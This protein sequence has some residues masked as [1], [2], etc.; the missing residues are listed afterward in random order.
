MQAGLG[1]SRGGA[2]NLSL[3][4]T[5]L[6]PALA[7]SGP[8]SA[9]GALFG[10]ALLALAVYWLRGLYVQATRGRLMGLWWGVGGWLCLFLAPIL[11]VPALFGLGAAALL[12]GEYWRGASRTVQAKN[13]PPASARAWPLVMTVL[14]LF[15]SGSAA[16]AL[17]TAPAAESDSGDLA[18]LALGL[19]CLLAGLGRLL[20]LQGLRQFGR[21]LPSSAPW[22]KSGFALRW[23]A[24][25]VPETPELSVSLTGRGAELHNVARGPLQLVGWSPAG[26]NAWLQVY[27]PAGTPLSSLDVGQS[28]FLPLSETDSGVRVWYTDASATPRLFRA[29]WTP[30]AQA[31]RRVLN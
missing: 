13:L 16:R 9:L 19:A 15:L 6:N 8:L 5:A 23:A 2:V 3:A 1:R 10:A 28:A 29:D 12:L 17:A 7:Q 22:L 27:G 26:N 30:A 31:S 25:S 21:R 11:Y 20:A 24:V 14:G 4:L 18:L